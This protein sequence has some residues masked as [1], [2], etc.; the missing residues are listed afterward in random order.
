[1]ECPN[2]RKANDDDDVSVVSATHASAVSVTSGASTGSQKQHAVRP[3]PQD[4]SGLC[5][6]LNTMHS[7][8]QTNFHTNAHLMEHLIHQDHP[9]N[10][11]TLSHHSMLP[12][13]LLTTRAPQEQHSLNASRTFLCRMN[14]I[15]IM[16]EVLRASSDNIDK[17]LLLATMPASTDEV[18]HGW[19][20]RRITEAKHSTDDVAEY[21]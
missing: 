17:Y 3:A 20:K 2:K 14:Y 13:L 1:M 16:F 6:D 8:F 21:H 15:C 12:M 7:A 11:L 18:Q 5:D 10:Y 4:V 19:L 9:I